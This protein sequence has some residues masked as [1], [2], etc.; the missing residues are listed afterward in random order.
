MGATVT[1]LNRL[2]RT[3]AFAAALLGGTT[4][5]AFAATHNKFPFNDHSAYLAP[6]AGLTSWAQTLDRHREQMPLLR[7]C[8]A[9]RKCRGRMRSY[10]R[11][12]SGAQALSMEEKIELTQRY[13][14]R[15]D[16]EDDRPRR[17]AD[18][19]GKKR[20]RRNHWA[21]LYEFL[22]DS[23]DCEDYATAKYFM[24]REFGVPAE[25]LRVVVA[26]DKRARGTHGLLAVRRD[27]G[28]I[29]LLD[30][31]YR[32]RRDNHSG[33]RYIYSMNEHSVWDHSDHAK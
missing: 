7:D 26:Y 17:L 10:H 22:R 31:D 2:P 15:S 24:L 1:R 27:D 20:W 28:Q 8:L 33:F 11:V 6:A 9:T 3:A 29:W 32:I 25:D 21:T 19:S 14:N 23:G 12:M 16:Y 30:S 4:L 5:I 13:L 18:P